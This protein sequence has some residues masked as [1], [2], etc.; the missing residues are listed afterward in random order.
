MM[1]PS[2][3][4]HPFMKAG[5]YDQEEGEGEEDDEGDDGDNDE[6]V[7]GEEDEM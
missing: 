3:V 6:E 1:Q 4:I 2:I 5:E 7:G